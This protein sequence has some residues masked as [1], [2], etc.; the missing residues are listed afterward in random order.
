MLERD[1][2]IKKIIILKKVLPIELIYKKNFFLRK[3]IFINK[4]QNLGFDQKINEIQNLIIEKIEN[5]NEKFKKD[6]NTLNQRNFFLYKFKFARSNINEIYLTNE[7]EIEIFDE[8]FEIKKYQTPYN[9]PKILGKGTAYIGFD[10][11]NIF[12]VGGAGQISY[13]NKDQLLKNN[14]K[15][16]FYTTYTN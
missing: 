6:L 12:I 8:E 5:Q 9:I 10:Q 15:K 3:T 1:T 2:Y 7:F 11:K 13:I 4:T 16:Q 14:L